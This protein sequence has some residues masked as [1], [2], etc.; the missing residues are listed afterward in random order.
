MYKPAIKI[1][2]ALLLVVIFFL[3][4]SLIENSKKELIVEK[5]KKEKRCSE[6]GVYI[7][8][9]MAQYPSYFNYI[10]Q[11]AKRSGLNTI[12]VDAKHMIEEPV[13][14]LARRKEIAPSAR[15]TADPWLAKLTKKLHQEGFIVSARIVVF[16]DDHLVIARPDLGIK[17]KTG[18][19]YRD[20]KQGRWANPYLEEV[21][22]YNILLAER[23]ALSGVDEIQFDYVRFP[24]EGKAHLAQYPTAK[25]AL[26]KVE[27]INLFLKSARERLKNFNVSIAVDI[28]GVTAWQLKEDVEALGQDLRKMAKYIDVISPMF[29]PSHFGAGYDGFE[30]P[31]EHPYYFVNAGVRKAKKILSG[32][33]VSIVPWIQGFDLR[34]PNFGPAYILDQI[35]ACNDEGV[36]NYLI[37][38]A[39]NVYD[40]AF[41]ALK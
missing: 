1:S 36:N 27:V 26:S 18:E 15:V 20:H 35:R 6:R 3:A 41:T 37:W 33:S 30:N 2:S 34:S 25:G 11:N 32:E 5:V 14:E 22:L 39:R 16:K 38:N 4:L 17:I 23:A 8:K 28:F 29:Y 24:A 12:V 40:T 10:K 13:L 9:H 7:T 21:R 31:G 19:L